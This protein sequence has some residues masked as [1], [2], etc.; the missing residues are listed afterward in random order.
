MEERASNNPQHPPD[1]R[2][3][4]R[5]GLPW[6]VHTVQVVFQ[7]SF[8]KKQGPGVAHFHVPVLLRRV[9]GA[10]HLW[11]HGVLLVRIETWNERVPQQASRF[12]HVLHIQ[13]LI[14]FDNRV[15]PRSPIPLTVLECD[16]AL[17]LDSA[18]SEYLGQ[19][20]R[21]LHVPRPISSM[22]FNVIH[23]NLWIWCVGWCY[24]R[25]RWPSVLLPSGHR[26]SNP[27]NLRP[28]T[29]ESPEIPRTLLRNFASASI[30][31]VWWSRPLRQRRSPRR[32][33][34]YWWG[35]RT[36]DHPKQSRTIRPSLGSI[37]KYKA[38]STENGS[39][40]FQK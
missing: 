3:A 36:A 40:W 5:P 19:H 8:D 32:L 34:L 1:Q 10:H 13:L 38:W 31:A 27:R 11:F 16:Y 9:V 17:H 20:P 28:E 22:V 35:G 2:A 24:W 14:I 37:L 26:A 7:L 6:P 30:W 25:R 29:H 4:I 15:I 33:V 12:P 39:I 21:N 23:Y 18:K